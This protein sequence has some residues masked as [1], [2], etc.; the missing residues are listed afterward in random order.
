MENKLKCLT[1][2][3]S[4]SLKY[5]TDFIDFSS[6]NFK[7]TRKSLKLVKKN[8]SNRVEIYEGKL[9]FLLE[10]LNFRK[11]TFPYE[12]RIFLA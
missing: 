9:E 6:R 1:N 8:S 12:F 11:V 7:F 10:K 5:R 3:F 4:S 2:I